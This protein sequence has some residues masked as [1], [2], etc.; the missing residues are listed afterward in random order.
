MYFNYVQE[1]LCST[2]KYSLRVAVAE[3]GGGGGKRQYDSI[4]GDDGFLKNYIH[5]NYPLDYFCFYLQ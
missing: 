2:S 4:D 3:E 5:N 1:S